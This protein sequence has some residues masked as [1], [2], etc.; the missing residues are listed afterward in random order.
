[1]AIWLAANLAAACFAAGPGGSVRYVDDSAPA[2]G[3]GLAWATAYRFLHDA[4]VEADSAR[5]ID[6]LRVAQGTY[7]PDESELSPSGTG[8][9]DAT[10]AVCGFP[11][12]SIQ[13]AQ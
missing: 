11:S 6:E 4:L 3:D 10:F 12:A 9:R 13:K 7:R 8:D 2:G 5:T 1:M